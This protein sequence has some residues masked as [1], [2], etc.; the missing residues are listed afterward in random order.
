[1][2]RY[3][4]T[5]KP[6]Q[7]LTSTHNYAVLAEI[8][9]DTKTILREMRF[10]SASYSTQTVYHAP[11]ANGICQVGRR[12]FV[13][14]FNYIVELDYDS[15][16][17]VNSFSHPY[18][19]DLHGLDADGE[20]LYVASTGIDAVLCFDINTFDL[21][22]RW[23]PDAPILYQ[24][25]VEADINRDVMVSIPLLGDKRRQQIERKQAF[26]DMDYRHMRKTMTGYHYHHLNDVVHQDNALYITTK[27]WNYHQKGAV[28]KLD[29]QTNQT[30]FIVKPDMLHG[31]HD[32]VWLDGRFYVTES[33]ANQVA[34]WSDGQVTHRKVE[35]A[36]YFVRGLCDTGES[37][38]VGFS[39]LRNTDKPALIVEY[40]RDFTQVISQMDVSGCYPPEKATTIHSIVRVH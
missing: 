35:P 34:W 2:S 18:M 1:V 19:V 27:Q 8:D 26:R 5:F 36:P 4:A 12:V 24:E 17:I 32:G 23:G 11:L 14:M 28:I 9:W 7:Y 20:C 21:L 40:N 37:W 39:T 10:P 15:F 30:D 3:L 38:L 22:W 29:L 25:R 16:Q 13:A 31:L 6:Q 33:G